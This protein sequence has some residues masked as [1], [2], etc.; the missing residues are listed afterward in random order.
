MSVG[1]VLI[2]DHWREQRLFTRRLLAAG[3]ITLLLTLFLIARLF[4]L[5]IVSYDHFRELSQGNRVRIEAIPPTRGLIFD[6]NGVLL[7]ENLPAYQL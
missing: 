5:Q 7:A 4:F 1:A 6:R 2:K 3:I